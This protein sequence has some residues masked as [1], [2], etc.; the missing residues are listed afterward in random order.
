MLQFW[1]PGQDLVTGNKGVV[2][3]LVKDKQAL[4]TVNI[5][6]SMSGTLLLI[7]MMCKW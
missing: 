2:F 6:R 5:R 7:D 4:V 3:P 1:P